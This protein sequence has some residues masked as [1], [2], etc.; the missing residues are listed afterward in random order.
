[1]PRTRILL[2]S[3]DSAVEAAVHEV[4][5]G[6]PLELTTISEI[7]ALR[8]LE[9]PEWRDVLAVVLDVDLPEAWDF[10]AV[11]ERLGGL[12]FDVSL[13]VVS[14]RSLPHGDR[15]VDQDPPPWSVALEKPIS[16]DDL[17][18]A[19]DREILLADYELRAPDRW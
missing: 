12:L 9:P 8:A 18:R 13:F 14:G 10:A 3:A 5:S 16:R 11:E 6:R 1:M 17:L 15:D 19:I 2:A 7:R 4:V